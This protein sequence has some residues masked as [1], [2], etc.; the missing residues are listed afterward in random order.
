M[1]F[2]ISGLP[3]YTDQSSR[4]FMVKSILGA[5]TLDILASAGS[6]DPTL[7]GNKAIQLADSDVYFQKNT[8]CARNPLGSLI[9]SQVTI[10]AVDIKIDSDWCV[11]DL[12]TIYA[13]E[14]MKAKM[15]GQNYDDVLFLDTIGEM[16]ASK[17]AKGLEDLAWQGDVSVTGI[18]NLNMADG[19]I[20]RIKNSGSY[21]NLSGATGATVSAKLKAVYNAMPVAVRKAEDFRI[22]ISDEMHDMYVQENQDKNWFKEEDTMK[23]VGTNAKLEVVSGLNDTGVVIAT[24]LRNLKAGGELEGTTFEKYFSHETKKVYLDS[25]FSIGFQIVYPQEIGLVKY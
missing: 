20:K 16:H 8:G 2:N 10:S 21:I 6:F 12:E 1:A 4:E 17:T 14:D 25:A 22:F 24:R 3:A 7:K 19:Y 18:T 13:V 11:R 23:V 9:L 5:K 15:K